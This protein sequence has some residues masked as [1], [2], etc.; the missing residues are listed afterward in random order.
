MT[1][2]QRLLTGMWTERSIFAQ[3]ES[4]HITQIDIK[5]MSM[6][7]K[8]KI[9][10]LNRISTEEFKEAEKLPLV[11]N[12][13]QVEAVKFSLTTSIFFRSSCC[14]KI[15]AFDTWF[16]FFVPL[17]FM[18]DTSCI[19]WILPTGQV[20]NNPNLLEVFFC[21]NL[22]PYLK[23]TGSFLQYSLNNFIVNGKVI[24]LYNNRLK[25]IIKPLEIAYSHNF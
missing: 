24:F 25:S 12:S 18:L 20:S 13:C 17:R 1:P 9:T 8:L 3:C 5:H 16:F 23:Y 4:L 22:L 11:S 21:V 15:F 10:E 7:R 2:F 6:N 14:S 19:L